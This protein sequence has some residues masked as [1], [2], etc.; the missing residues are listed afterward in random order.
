M[1]TKPTKDATSARPR[2]PA[3]K[4]Q[5]LV[6]M[7]RGVIKEVKMAALD[8]DRKMSHVFEEA[9]REW[10]AKRKARKGIASK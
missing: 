10:L 5:V 4:K 6:I 7:D 2:A 3:G 8:D 9:A 1:P